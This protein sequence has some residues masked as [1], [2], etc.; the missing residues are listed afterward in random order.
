MSAHIL[1]GQVCAQR[2][3]QQLIERLHRVQKETNIIPGLA[4]IQVGDNPASEV[5]VASKIRQCAEVGIRS[6]RYNFTAE[7]SPTEVIE[8]LQHLNQDSQVHGI[9]VQLPL[10]AHFDTDQIINTIDPLK[11]VDGLH[12]VN[13]G[14][15]IAGVPHTVPCTPRGCLSLIKEYRQDLTGLNAT[16]LGR[17]ILVGKPMALILLRENCTVTIAHSK[18]QNLTDICRQADILVVAVGLPQLV[19]KSWIKPGAIVLDVG[20][21]RQTDQSLVGD[22][23]FDN[24]KSVAGALTPVP[25]GIGPMTVVSLLQNTVDLMMRQVGLNL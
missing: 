23:D 15:L 22:V 20:I 7:A 17:S 5:Y 1:Q 25:G 2:L 12:H 8:K 4:V 19:K 3:K 10:P 11:D 6:F 9:L 21:N 14:A 16:V 13:L 18:T 24:V